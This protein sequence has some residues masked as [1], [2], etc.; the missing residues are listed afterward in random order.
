MVFSQLRQTGVNPI[1]SNSLEGD[2]HMTTKRLALGVATCLLVIGVGAGVYATAQN[3]NQDPRPFRDAGP[4]GPGGRGGRMGGPG[5]PMGMMPMLARELNVTDAQKAQIKTI[6]DSH[7][8]EWNALADRARTTHEALQQAVTADTVDEGLIRQRSAEVAAVDADMAVARA[9][10]HAEVFQ[11]LTPEQK[12][13]AKTLQSTFAERMKQ[14]G[15]GR[16]AH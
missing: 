10:V 7:R 4:G 6:A 16:G 9:R 5:G 1:L 2:R 12:A 3:T 15:R 13:Q 11:I 14:R 8:D